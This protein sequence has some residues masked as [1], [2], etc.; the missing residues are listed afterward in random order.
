MTTSISAGTTLEGMPRDGV[1]A[2][3]GL[4]AT[5]MRDINEHYRMRSWWNS[6]LSLSFF[7][8]QS[9]HT[10]RK[11]LFGTIMTVPLLRTRDCTTALSKSLPSLIAPLT[12]YVGHARGRMVTILAL[13]VGSMNKRP[14]NPYTPG[15]KSFMA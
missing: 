5:S 9:K 4:C 1:M 6:S 11:I 8:M 14:K 12:R 7:T 3:S 15:S 13:L 10:C 2:S